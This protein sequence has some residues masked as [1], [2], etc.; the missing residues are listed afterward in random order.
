MASQF[1]LKNTPLIDNHCHPFLPIKRRL[2]LTDLCLLLQLGPRAVET[3]TEEQKREWKLQ[4]VASPPLIVPRLI[5]ELG[6]LYRGEDR[7]ISNLFQ[8]AEAILGERYE[9]AQDYSEYIKFL[10]DD[11]CLK[12]I[13]VDTGYPQP[14]VNLEAF[15]HT[16]YREVR[17]IF[18]IESLTDELLK[19]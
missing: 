7:V 15:T 13:V 3:A 4:Y 2:S 16:I 5:L 1:T 10:F 18:R 11:I 14:P 19:R 17:H 6:K 9:R 12:R 8:E